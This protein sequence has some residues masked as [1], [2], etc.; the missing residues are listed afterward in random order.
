MSSQNLQ[1][2]EA[3]G[4]DASSPRRPLCL[5]QLHRQLQS[6]DQENGPSPI[7][8]RYSGKKRRRDENASD[9]NSDQPD[10]ESVCSNESDAN[11]DQPDDESGCSDA[12]DDDSDWRDDDSG[13]S[14]AS[15]DDSDW[16]K[17]PA[18][19]CSLR[20]EESF[21]R[22]AAHFGGKKASSGPLLTSAGRRW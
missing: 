1:R 8:K 3:A 16:R 18:G 11:S 20:R 13:C 10:D 5:V 6:Q 2:D 22:A 15:D 12:S 7:R 14:D 4:D 9:A 19:R 17:L 21:Q